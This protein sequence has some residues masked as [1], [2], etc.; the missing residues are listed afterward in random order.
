MTP[1]LVAIKQ[2]RRTRSIRDSMPLKVKLSSSDSGPLA[3]VN[4]IE[5]R[6]QEELVCLMS[7]TKIFGL[8]VGLKKSG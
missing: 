7:T 1:L 2:Q 8:R 3:H 6:R 4:S 5:V